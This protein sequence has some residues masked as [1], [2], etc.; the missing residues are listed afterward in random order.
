MKLE[1]EVH[2]TIEQEVV[3]KTD[4]KKEPRIVVG[5]KIIHNNVIY[6]LACGVSES[7]HYGFEIDSIENKAKSIGYKK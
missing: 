1:F 5:Y 6:V 2:F 4:I 7:N 3:L